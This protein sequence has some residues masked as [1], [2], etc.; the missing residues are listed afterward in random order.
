[1]ETL[2]EQVVRDL[3]ICARW[4]TDFQTINLVVTEE[5]TYAC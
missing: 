5:E 4:T 3:H 2:R 1:M